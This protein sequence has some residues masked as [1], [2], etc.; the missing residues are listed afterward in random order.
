MTIGKILPPMPDLHQRLDEALRFVAGTDPDLAF[1]MRSKDQVESILSRWQAVVA[2]HIDDI[3]AL[4][5]NE[6]LEP[7]IVNSA[8]ETLDEA[9]LELAKRHGKSTLSDFEKRVSKWK[10]RP[11]LL[12]EVKKEL[13][14]KIPQLAYLQNE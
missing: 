10:D 7:L 5:T 4:Q 8:C 3:S 9:I 13:A 11:A 6:L 1:R 2:E 12:A 14:E